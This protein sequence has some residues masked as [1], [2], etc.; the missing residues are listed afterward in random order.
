MAAGELDLAPI[1]APV[2]DW[3]LVEPSV[4]PP[5]AFDLAFEVDESCRPLTFC[6]RRRP[7]TPTTWRIARVFDEYRGP[8]LPPGERAW[9]SDTSSVPRI[10]P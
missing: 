7:P 6:G 2:P 10:T 9:P 4:Y 8:N 1:I 3:Q 5:V